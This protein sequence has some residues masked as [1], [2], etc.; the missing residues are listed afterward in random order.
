MPS[1]FPSW[2]RVYAFFAHWRDTGQVTESHERLREAVRA[3]EGRSPEP[4]AAVVDSRAVKPDATV[5]HGSCEFD[6][7]KKI[8]GRKRHLLTDTL[9]LLLSVLVTPTSTTDVAACAPGGPNCPVDTTGCRLMR[10][11]W[12]VS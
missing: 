5:A 7:G 11:C 3:D 12:R 8:N 4:S 6:A 2:P 10:I 9:G 1:D